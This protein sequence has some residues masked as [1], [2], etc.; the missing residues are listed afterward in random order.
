MTF[1]RIHAE[2]ELAA[3]PGFKRAKDDHVATARQRL[4]QEDTAAVLEL[5]TTHRFLRLV[6]TIL[7]IVL[8]LK[9]Q[10]VNFA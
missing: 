8:N 5:G 4:S 3:D 6:Q 2:N 10:N 7:A 1:V 9:K